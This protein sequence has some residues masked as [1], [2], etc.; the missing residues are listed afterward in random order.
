M[1]IKRD[2]IKGQEVEV[3]NGYKELIEDGEK[4]TIYFLRNLAIHNMGADIVH[5]IINGGDE[6]SIQ[7]NEVLTCG[8]IKVYSLIVVEVG[9][10]IRYMG[11]EG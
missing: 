3:N 7:P 6:I 1:A 2:K 10:H 11:I 5:V 9:S 8:D 4:D